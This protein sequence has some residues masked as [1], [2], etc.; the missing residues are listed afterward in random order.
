M[1]DAKP[2]PETP[3]PSDASNLPTAAG[4]AIPS[5]QPPVMPTGMPTVRDLGTTPAFGTFQMRAGAGADLDDVPAVMATMTGAATPTGA[6]PAMPHE[7]Y[8]LGDE[9]ARGG[10]GRVVEARDTVLG[11]V[12]ALKEALALDSDSLKR[13][14]RETR[15][16]ARLEHPSIVPVHDAGSMAGG[17][18]YY[19]MRK[20][21]GRPLEKLV[22]RAETL[23]ER[24][25]LIPHIVAA[26]HAVAH[27]HER[28]IVH[29]DIKPSNIL[30]GD[31]GET[32]VI[33]WGLA[34]VIGEPDDPLVDSQAR[35]QPSATDD[36]DSI[37]TRAGIVYGTPGFMAPEQLR[38]RPVNERCDVYALGA[39]LYHLLSRKPPHHAKTADEMMQAAAH[40]PPPP[41][42][43]LVAGVP[44]ELS[45]IIDKCLAHDPAA[46]YPNARELAEDLNRFL[47]GQLVA[48]HHYSPSVRVRRFVKKHKVPV[49]IAFGAVLL[50]LLA[51]IRVVGERNRA[52]EAARA[53][54]EEK[55]VAE[56]ERARAETQLERV[57]LQQARNEVETN[58]TRAVAMIRHLAAKHPREVRS[59]AIAA[60]AAGV[61][62]GLP[63]SKKT[64]TLEMSRDG[65]RALAAGEDGVIRIYDLAARSVKTV[66]ELGERV[67]ARFADQERRIVVWT[68][69]KLVVIDAMTGARRELRTPTA[70]RDL[71]VVGVTAYW[72]DVERRLWM[73]DVDLAGSPPHEIAL[74][75]PVDQLAPSPDGRWIAL[76]GEDHLLLFDRTQPA[77]E[78]VVIINGK[79]VDVDWSGDGSHLATLVDDS[80]LGVK[81][82]PVPTIV[83]RRNV[84]VRRYVAYGNDRVYS[85]GV[86]GVTAIPAEGLAPRKPLVGDPLGLVEARGHTMI[87]GSRGGIA[88]L[89]DTGD[90]AFTVPTGRVDI[91]EASPRS[92]YVIAT[93]EDR[94]L[95]WNLDEIQPRKVPLAQIE[96]ARFVGNDLVLATSAESP[97]QWIDLATGKQQPAGDRL[98]LR[99]IVGAPGGT[100]A[101]AIDIARKAHL[102]LRGR[103]AEPLDGTVSHA[104]FATDRDL[105][106]ADDAGGTL[107]H[108]DVETRARKLLVSRPARLASMAWSRG[109]RWSEPANAGE[110]GPIRGK[111]TWVA[112]AFTDGT[113][114]RSDLAT[115]QHA[116]ATSP[117]SL[118]TRLL[119]LA[120]GTVM[121]AEGRVLRAWR[122]DGGID[123]H[124]TLPKPVDAL[125]IA[126][127]GP[128]IA[129]TSE[130]AAYL[131]GLDARDRIT[132]ADPVNAGRAA[133]AVDT[134]VYVVSN[135]D[136]IDI[137][138]PLAPHRWTLARAQSNAYGEPQ[139]SSDGQRVM[140]HSARALLVWTLLA[141]P[142]PDELA[143]WLA[144]LSNATLDPMG[145]LGWL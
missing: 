24:L 115:G 19:V 89:A 131:V 16:T 69:P 72:V 137:I 31:L 51:F 37:K 141:P 127:A 122:P 116:V 29:R 50:L 17:A 82:D 112:A 129:F 113:L 61:A 14:A 21:S 77:A 30:A 12:V 4:S 76:Y 104:G 28:G 39:T 22:A 81:I 87:A 145:R 23:G 34:K 66:A 88:V 60:R 90:L 32:I 62:W 43:E 93:I 74:A 102:V 86:S 92:P 42:G 120:D 35:P 125:G 96:L 130:G 36:H 6:P 5:P 132:E 57:T 27:A 94:L 46:R 3:T 2:G 11:R 138:D 140:A 135:L 20:I 71:E 79:T 134:G 133:M 143:G 78:P 54:V 64:F 68:G 110:R 65:L 103:S 1:D 80:A 111:P 9:I 142:S 44:P 73:L 124:A 59:I 121:F 91:I 100:A 45:T 105:L 26:S 114:W 126:G 98:Q 99:D 136:G 40:A 8:E 49:G 101:C 84:G 18:P 106:L 139:I 56:V 117:I 70:I 119:V 67:S 13:F 48:S 144:L 95:V 7:R 109:P 108:L 25:A 123:A 107:H 10:M 97:L 53:A 38:G 33:D 41:I 52:D 85:I 58:P 63:A 128:I 75:E 83:H 47:T 55:R 15:I 118:T